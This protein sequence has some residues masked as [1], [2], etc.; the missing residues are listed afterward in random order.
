MMNRQAVAE[1]LVKIAKELI[2][3]SAIYE[4]VASRLPQM[5]LSDIAGII[6][7]DWRLVDYAAKPYL[8]AMFS[9]NS[10]RDSYTM[11]SGASIV[12][13]FLSNATRYRGE[14]AKAIK[15]ELSRRLKSA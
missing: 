10:I 2:A 8:H 6:S 13:Y 12:A 1:E 9:L 3:Q 11:D 5:S 4:D 14:L 7:R 15:K